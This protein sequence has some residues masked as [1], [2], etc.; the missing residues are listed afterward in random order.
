MVFMIEC[1]TQLC[2]VNWFPFSGHFHSVNPICPIFYSYLTE[3]AQIFCL[4]EVGHFSS[5]IFSLLNLFA[6]G[7][8]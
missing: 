3:T 2:L 5:R 4:M 8:A 7:L 1:N 6:S